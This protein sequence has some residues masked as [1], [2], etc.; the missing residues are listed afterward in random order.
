MKLQI[1]GADRP[2]EIQRIKPLSHRYHKSYDSRRH[3]SHHRHKS[4]N[5]TFE[6]DSILKSYAKADIILNRASKKLQPA[7]RSSLSMSNSL[8]KNATHLHSCGKSHRITRTI[9]LYPKKVR[10]NQEFNATLSRLRF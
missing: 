9:G 7:Q 2:S 4:S 5:T 10:R 6:E 3:Q 1:N 8:L